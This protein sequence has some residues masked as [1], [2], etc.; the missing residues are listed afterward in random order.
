[1]E[2]DPA[3]RARG[4]ACSARTP[5]G[6]EC[7]YIYVR[8]EYPQSI[9][10]LEKAIEEAKKAN[11][12]GENILGQELLVRLQHV[13]SGAGAY[14][15]G[16]ETGLLESLEGKR[17]HPRIKPP[18]PAIEGA[19]GCPTVIN[20]VE[21]LAHVPWILEHG[22]QA[23]AEQGI[24]PDPDNPRSMGSSGTKLM[25]VSGR[26]AKP[27]RL[28]VRV[29]HHGVKPADLRLRGRAARGPFKIKAVIPGGL[30][31]PVLTD[32]ELDVKMGFDDLVKVGSGLGN[33][34]APS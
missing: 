34:T 28:G 8:G 1:M 11:L 24:A 7:I 33:G 9:E 20:N 18:F 31:M 3:S 14:I 32:D 25:G 12:L 17:G 15:C 2:L 29:R 23:F 30:S 19:F 16:E 21:T 13:H 26:H 27:R 4:H 10:R 6:A 5:C 22:G